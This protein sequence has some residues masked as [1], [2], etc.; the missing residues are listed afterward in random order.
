MSKY[1]AWVQDDGGTERVFR[2]P[3]L[4]H[5]A[6]VAPAVTDDGNSGYKVGSFWCD[7]TADKAYVCVDHTVGASVWVEVTAAAGAGAPTDAEYV[8]GALHAS[9][10]NERLVTNTATVTW[11]VSLAN[12][13]KANVVTDSMSVTSGAGGLLLSG[14]VSVLVDGQFYGYRQGARGWFCV[15]PLLLAQAACGW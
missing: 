10:S 5:N 9:L 15:R 7:V 13:A 8:V 12:Q 1:L 14:D 11:D 4:K 3:L 6:T 2:V